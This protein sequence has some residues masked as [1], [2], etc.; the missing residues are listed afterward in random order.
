MN[1]HLP[2]LVIFLL[3][4]MVVPFLSFGQK[5]I[6]IFDGKTFNGWE[7]DTKNTWRI[8]N[9][10]IVGG[11]LTHQVPQNEFLCTTKSYNNFRLR[12][13]F[14]LLGTEGFINSG[15]QF[16]SVRH[17]DPPNEMI[18]YQADL[19]D[20]YWASIYDESRRNKTLTPIDTA[21]INRTLKREQ[22][23][24]YEIHCNGNRIQLYLNG[25]KTADY[26]EE[27]G[28]I[29]QTGLIG[30]QIHGGGKAEVHFRDIVV[31]EL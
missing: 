6:S 1:S 27:D 22:W 23:N 25:A 24:S 12:L 30:L 18:G 31:E 21:L 26:I 3:A 16:R 19:G 11:S 28:R 15:V 9:G 8:E 4:I 7:G 5:T 13:K 14:R 2:A 10:A 20:G 17:T 29:P